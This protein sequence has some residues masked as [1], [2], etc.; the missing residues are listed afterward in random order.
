MLV[1]RLLLRILPVK[2]T[3]AI[4]ITFGLII[5][6]LLESN[7]I[8]E[9]IQFQVSREILVQVHLGKEV[10]DMIVLGVPW[11]MHLLNANSLKNNQSI[12]L[13]LI[14]ILIFLISHTCIHLNFSSLP[15][16]PL[17]IYLPYSSPNQQFFPL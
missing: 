14:R 13:Q 1:S 7:W 2:E 3:T 8:R 15:I 6:A 10:R 16:L 5:L 11:G 4:E 17:L 9:R 12:T